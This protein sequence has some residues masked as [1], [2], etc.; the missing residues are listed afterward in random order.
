MASA[1]ITE[2]VA[3][4]GVA[5]VVPEARIE[6]S[7][8]VG[9]F[10][11]EGVEKFAKM[12]GVTARHVATANQTASDFACCAAERLLARLDWA[13][14]SIDALV[15]VSQTP[16]YTL[17]AKACVLH[18]RLG[19]KTDCAAFDMNLGCSGFV[20]GLLVAGN[21]C[22][23][24]AFRRVLLC[25][26]DTITKLVS[27]HDRSAAMLFGDGGFAV[28]L[29]HD[30]AAPAW[31][32]LFRTHG[33]GFREIIVPTGAFRHRQG[34]AT[35]REFGDGIV[36]GDYDLA[37]NGT[38]VFNFT[39]SEVPAAIRQQMQST[40]QTVETTDLLVMHQANAFIL[41]NIA[42]MTKFPMTKVPISM[43]R[44]GNTS[45]TSIPLTLCDTLSGQPD[46]VP[47]NLLLAGFG[48]GLSWGIVSLR[49]PP[50]VCLPITTC[51]NGYV[52][53]VNGGWHV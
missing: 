3:I 31:S 29:E 46:S 20:Y 7:T 25:G 48:V 14:D 51:A 21:L 34:D 4:R 22:R 50:S 26:G 39:I 47:L 6:N 11:G 27:P 10:G 44:Y 28:A 32:W 8:F 1:G 17:P 35:P 13:R 52:D 5:S 9:R 42:K 40:G 53:E 24:N 15:F 16:D 23:K 41:K 38:E 49:L 37:M 18:H 19:I 36:R 12:T 43:D 2:Q 30:E 45:V 33:G